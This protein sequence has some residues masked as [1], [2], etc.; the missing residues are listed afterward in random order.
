MIALEH[1]DDLQQ[2]ADPRVRDWVQVRMRLCL[3]AEIALRVYILDA[4]DAVRRCCWEACWGREPTAR[5]RLDDLF[6]VVESVEPVSDGY[7]L[8]VPVH[9]EAALIVVIP[10]ASRLDPAFADYLQ[11]AS[12][13]ES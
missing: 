8:V 1:L 10:R 3:E 9:H 5:D 7:A 6:A 2:I 12:D 13:T 11:Q 4:R